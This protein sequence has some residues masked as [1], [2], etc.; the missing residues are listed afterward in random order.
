MEK[1]EREE[2]LLR[3]RSFFKERIAENHIKNTEKLSSLKMFN[4]N[5]FFVKYLA[6][7]VFGEATSENIARAL[8]YPRILGTSISTSFGS[9][10]QIF[11]NEILTGYASVIP[12]IDIEFIDSFDGRK[13]YCQIKTGPTTINKDDVKTILDHFRNIK[14]LARTNRQTDINPSIDCI[15]GVFYGEQNKLSTFYKQISQDYTVI[16]GQQF[17]HHLTGDENF[18]SDLANAVAEVAVEMDSRKL[19]EDTVQKL[20]FEIKQRNGIE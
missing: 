13:K 6:N 5:P 17:W 16:V 10:L 11:C 15:V 8:I 12:G 2:I 19:I 4:V 14:N 9:Q 20:A 18:Y 7:F 3:A 1:E